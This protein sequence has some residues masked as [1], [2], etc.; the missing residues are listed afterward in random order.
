MT[1]KND[2]RAAL[3]APFFMRIRPAP[4]CIEAST[5]FRAKRSGRRNPLQE[6]DLFKL[7]R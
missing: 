4:G 7:L 1:L 2:N 6:R 3:A 5:A